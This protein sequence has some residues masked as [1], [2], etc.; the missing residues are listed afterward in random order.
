M[1]F[2]VTFLSFMPDFI[3]LVVCTWKALL[4][5]N[6]VTS[7]LDKFPVIIPTGAL[8]LILSP[9][10]PF[11]KD[12]QPSHASTLSIIYVVP[13]LVPRIPEL[14]LVWPGVSTV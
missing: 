1:S 12:F 2:D 10:P 14:S 4:S 5:V 7:W 8:D 3:V 9:P 11:A 6:F 13:L